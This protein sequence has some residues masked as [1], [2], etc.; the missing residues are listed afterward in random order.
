[1]QTAL[2]TTTKV[3]VGG[4]VEIVAPQL[5]ANELVEVI[6]IFPI[7]QES[8]TTPVKRSVMDILRESPGHRI[9]KTAA[10]VD[11]YLMEEHNAWDN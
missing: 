5:P 2:K 11:R 6:I 8:L 4:K 3:L 1:M 9:F 7:A 10:D